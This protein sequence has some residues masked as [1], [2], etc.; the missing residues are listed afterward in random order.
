MAT[1]T[2]LV[3]EED[4][5]DTEAWPEDVA[6]AGDGLAE[7]RAPR[8][9]V[10]LRLSIR[11]SS[12]SA[13]FV[14]ELEVD[15]GEDDDA[16]ESLIGTT[17][18]VGSRGIWKEE[19]DGDVMEDVEEEKEVDE[20]NDDDEEDTDDDGVTLDGVAGMLTGIGWGVWRGV[21]AARS[22]IRSS[23]S[24]RSTRDEAG[25]VLRGDDD[26]EDDEE[27]DEDTAVVADGTTLARPRPRSSRRES[28]SSMTMERSNQ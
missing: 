18:G 15:V 19:D 9:E 21:G 27:D 13:A 5:E 12:S 25:R 22:S 2:L 23:S 3:A 11:A 16:R 14:D 20:G 24:L 26:N 4:E 8:D 17:L 28:R 7:R 1:T 10:A 6:D